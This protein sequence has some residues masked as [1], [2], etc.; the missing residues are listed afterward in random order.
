[1][2][3]CV[4]VCVCIYIYT[5]SYKNIFIS[6]HV[7]SFL[8]RLQ[9]SCVFSMYLNKCVIVTCTTSVSVYINVID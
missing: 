4:Y 5:N 3:V 8:L 6:M 1:M 2:C 7:N 9:F